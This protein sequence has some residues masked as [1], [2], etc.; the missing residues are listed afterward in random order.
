MR[1][2]LGAEPIEP[3]REKTE[4]QVSHEDKVFNAIETIPHLPELND[5]DE[6]T[7]PLVE[8]YKEPQSE[9]VPAE[10][11]VFDAFPTPMF[12]G[13]LDLDHARISQDVRD[14]VS[15][16]KERSN[17]DV[18]RN[19]T[20]YFDDD[21]RTS[22]HTL[23]WYTTFSNILKD[24]YIQFNHCEFGRRVNHLTRQ[25]IHLFAW[26]NRYEG[27]H[28]HD[29]HNHIN[30]TMSGTYYPLV[31]EGSSPIKFY[32]PNS[33]QGFAH[34]ES[35]EP[36]HHEETGVTTNGSVDMFI[37]PRLG[38]FLMWPSYM[39]HQVS[40]SGD[41]KNYERISI[42]FNL[43]HNEPLQETNSGDRLSY[44]FMHE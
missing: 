42:S 24:T 40:K 19:Y 25:D 29:T 16:V 23:D 38:E 14:M 31:N 37:Q 8:S 20:T 6:W 35:K 21:I 32:N 39:M 2:P 1:P 4:E 33:L 26:V 7:E 28:S 12:R 34:V 13:Y 36:Y 18:N 9:F 3:R 27:E 10:G 17:D 5:K 44:G 30:S 41:S 22:M 11:E 43:S 15:K